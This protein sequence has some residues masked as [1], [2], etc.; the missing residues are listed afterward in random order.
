M[1]QGVIY[2]ATNT[3]TGK[4]YVGLTTVGVDKR[5]SN[6]VTYSRSPKTYFHKAIAKY[7]PSAFQV[8]EY[9][10]AINKEFLSNLE[11]DVIQ[12]IKPEYNQTNGGEVTFG[13]KYNDETKERIRLK[14]IGKKRTLEQKEKNRE[15]KVAWFASHPEH[16]QKV[17]QQLAKARLLVDET[18]RLAAVQQSAKN[19]SWSEESRSKLSASCKGRKHAPDVIARMAA[20]KRRK[21]V[22]VQTGV[23]YPCAADA[24]AVISAH[25]TS[26]NAACKHGRKVYGFNFKYVE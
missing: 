5:W 12:Q 15:Q 3:I 7:G 22:C 8:K 16:K 21:V 4:Q 26:V 14:N 17:A 23:V 13:R 20:S 10:S 6:H 18:K 1:N 19:R 9:A 25:K 24:A 11:K 2:V